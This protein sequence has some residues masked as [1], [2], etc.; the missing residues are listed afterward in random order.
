MSAA[1]LTPLHGAGRYEKR[2]LLDCIVDESLKKISTDYDTVSMDVVSGSIPGEIVAPHAFNVRSRFSIN[3]LEVAEQHFSALFIHTLTIY[4]MISYIRPYMM[5]FPIEPSQIDLFIR[6]VDNKGAYFKAPYYA[7][8]HMNTA[9]NECRFYQWNTNSMKGSLTNQPFTQKKLDEV[10]SQTEDFKTLG[11]PRFK[12]NKTAI[13]ILEKDIE[14][15][16]KRFAEYSYPVIKAIAKKY[17]LKIAALRNS[18]FGNKSYRPLSAG[19]WSTSHCM[20][21]TE[22]QSFTHAFLQEYLNELSS[23]KIMEKQCQ[24]NPIDMKALT[25]GMN[26]F[27][28]RISFWDEYADRLEEPYIAMIQCQDGKIMYFTADEGQRL[29]LVKEEPIPEDLFQN[30]KVTDQV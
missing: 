19:F 24:N 16:Y 17:D 21:L 23:N 7:A 8:T 15:N 4:N 13:L 25:D 12:A 9:K 29:Q 30:N 28:C 10:V 18:A 3:S 22:A 14:K 27:C 6:Y 2:P 20:N 26:W 11:V 5:V 1:G